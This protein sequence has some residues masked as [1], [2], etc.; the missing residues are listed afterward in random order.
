VKVRTGFVSNSSTTSF[1][2]YGVSLRDKSI[3]LISAIKKFRDN[4]FQKFQTILDELLQVNNELGLFLSDLDSITDEE[5]LID[6]LIEDPF[7]LG[8]MLG[9]IKILTG[10][11]Y[12]VYYGKSW[13][14]IKD[15]ETGAQ[16]KERINKKI[17]KIFGDNVNAY[18]IAD[19]WYA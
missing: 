11:S 2:I 16:F 4:N 19:A 9:N 12:M 7:T 18:T 14:E 3:D 6:L 8:E 15:D 13:D 10:S 5:T 17:R 1:L